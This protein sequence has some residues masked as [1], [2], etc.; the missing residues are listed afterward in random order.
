MAEIVARSAVG[1]LE[2]AAEILG[3]G[4][5]FQWHMKWGDG[6]HGDRFYSVKQ[7]EEVIPLTTDTCQTRVALGG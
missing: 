3:L 1:F 5:W 6:F 7:S 4:F 2:G